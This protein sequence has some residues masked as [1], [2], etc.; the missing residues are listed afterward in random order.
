MIKTIKKGARVQITEHFNSREY[1]CRCN[2]CST[3]KYY[4]ELFMLLE[5]LRKNIRKPIDITGSGYRCAAHNAEVA[6]ASKDS[7]HMKGSAADIT[8]KG[9]SVKTLAKAAET[10]GFTGIIR[11]DKSN[12]VHVDLR[13]KHFYTTD[14]GSKYKTVDTFGGSPKCPFPEPSATVALGSSGDA[15]RWLEWHLLMLG[16]TATLNGSITAAEINTLK[17]AQKKLGLEQDGRCGP[18]SKKALK[19]AVTQ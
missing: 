15:A 12:F 11:Y 17:K 6:N 3:T 8:V 4:E 18:A 5:V 10:A 1:D 19:K 14:T 7:N 13:P 16:Y 9:M 2:I